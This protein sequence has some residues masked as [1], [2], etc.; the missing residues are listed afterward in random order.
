M[1]ILQSIIWSII[2]LP[3]VLCTLLNLGSDRTPPQ[4]PPPKE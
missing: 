2:L 3:L 1:G 4:P